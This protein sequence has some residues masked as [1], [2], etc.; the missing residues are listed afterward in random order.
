MGIELV[1]RD[2]G[3]FFWRFG[4]NGECSLINLYSAASVS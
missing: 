4:V 3:V 1:A 2:F